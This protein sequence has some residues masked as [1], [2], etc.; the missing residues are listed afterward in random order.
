VCCSWGKVSSD[1]ADTFSR[2]VM[3]IQPVHFNIHM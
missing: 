1:A 3:S 2:F